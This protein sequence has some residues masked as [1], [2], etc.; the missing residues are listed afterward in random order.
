[1]NYQKKSEGQFECVGENT[2]KYITFSVRIQK[3][4]YNGKTVAYKLRFTDS[5]RCQAHY[6]AL[7]IIYLKGFIKKM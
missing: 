6:Q 1:M 3:E 2:A 4:L 7:L 5:F